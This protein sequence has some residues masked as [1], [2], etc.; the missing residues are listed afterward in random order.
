LYGT[1]SE[2]AALLSGKLGEPGSKYQN[3]FFLDK[4]RMGELRSI[5]DSARVASEKRASTKRF[6]TTFISYNHQDDE[7]AQWL[8]DYL[9]SFGIECWLDKKSLRP[10]AKIHKSV[11]QAITQHDKLLLCAS[12]HSLQSWWVD[13]EIENAILKEQLAYKLS[14]QE[15]SLVLIPLNLDGFLF[16]SK[17]N[18]G[19]KAQITSRLAPDFHGWEKFVRFDRAT[20][21]ERR[22]LLKHLKGEEGDNFTS[23]FYRERENIIRALFITHQG[24]EG[25]DATSLDG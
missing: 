11:E 5:L 14:A 2:H 8:F 16:S 24:A 20:G 13:N 3:Y 6:H 17:W 23:R 15:E 19:W 10:G 4:D 22:R 21:N 12:K 7:F 25:Q 1:Q 9:K 18:N